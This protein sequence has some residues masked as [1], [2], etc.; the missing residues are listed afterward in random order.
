MK[1]L[2]AKVRQFMGI[3]PPPIK[4]GPE[5]EMAHNILR[6]CGVLQ[7]T[8]PKPFNTSALLLYRSYHRANVRSIVADLTFAIH[9]IEDIGY[10]TRVTA[11]S[12]RDMQVDEGLS[13][14]EFAPSGPAHVAEYAA[15]ITRL[16]QMYQNMLDDDTTESSHTVMLLTGYLSVHQKLLANYVK[17]F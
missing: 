15:A 8:L 7:N 16:T 12:M 4:H 5:K 3:V 11:K 10:V 13:L 17:C 1:K 2:L 9:Q 14:Y 6:D